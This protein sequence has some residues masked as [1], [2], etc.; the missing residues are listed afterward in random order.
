MEQKAT[1]TTHNDG[2]ILDLIFDTT[3]NENAVRW[4]PTAFSDHFILFYTL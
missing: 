1:F 4:Q 2:G 3:L